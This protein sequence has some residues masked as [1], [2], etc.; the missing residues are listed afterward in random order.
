MQRQLAVDAFVRLVP[1]LHGHHPLRQDEEVDLR[2]PLHK[3]ARRLAYVAHQRNIALDELVLLLAGRLGERRDDLLGG[4]AIPANDDNVRVAVAMP[5]ERASHACA[6]SGGPAHENSDGAICEAA[7]RSEVGGA[8]ASK[9]WH[10]AQRSS[11]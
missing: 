7:T 6:D 2:Q 11:K 9:G 8:D 3:L 5:G 10:A 4:S 1:P